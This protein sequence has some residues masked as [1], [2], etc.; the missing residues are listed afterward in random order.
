MKN[1][2]L[3]AAVLVAL[4]LLSIQASA[5][6]LI[7]IPAAGIAVS[8][9]TGQPTGGTSAY[10]LCNTT[11]NFC[12]GTSTPPSS[13]LYNTCAVFPSSIT[14]S[15]VSGFTLVA[16]I[17]RSISA[18]NTYTNNTTVT[19]A[20][21]RD[22]V[23]RNSA[24]TECI[25]GKRISMSDTSANTN[26]DFNP[27]LANRQYME[28]N[29]IAL[30]GFSSTAAANLQVG[31]YY[32]S[33]TDEV[34]F[35]IG[36]AFTGVQMQAD[37]SNTNNVAANYYKQPLTTPAPTSGKEING[38]G[39]TTTPPG[40]PAQSQQTA[41]IRSNWF[42]FTTDVTPFDEDG[43]SYKDSAMLYVRA[44][45]TSAAPVAVANTVRIRQAGQETQPLVTV[46]STGY[47]PPGANSNF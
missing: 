18:N 27:S 44:A 3:K 40:N 14:T 33:A 47:A 2:V 1:L 6:G 34:I 37:A 25:Y 21:M 24:N 38:V 23:W 4:G 13:T 36:K 8:A 30:G 7:N 31:Y 22:L 17:I 35:R 43:T 20:S 16:D 39:Q 41:E 11:G 12:S 26:V 10:A 29:D 46:T 32:T 5:T 15:P 28:V 9:G 45:C 19:I 42:D